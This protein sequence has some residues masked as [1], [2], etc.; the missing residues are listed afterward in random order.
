[1][2]ALLKLWSLLQ[3]THSFQ[4]NSEVM[5]TLS[6]HELPQA[7]CHKPSL[8]MTSLTVLTS[9][10]SICGLWEQNFWG[11]RGPLLSVLG[12][13]SSV[14]SLQSSLLSPRSSILGL[15]SSILD[16]QASTLSPQG[17]QPH[18]YWLVRL[19]W[20]LL[21]KSLKKFLGTKFYVKSACED[22]SQVVPAC[23]TS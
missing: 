7:K 6:W 16:P 10:A 15:Q 18:N 3:N 1:M 11:P 21:L 13:Q 19:I 8:L 14:L 23:I 4:T 17:R 5:A 20:C 2:A 22:A 9:F 12:L